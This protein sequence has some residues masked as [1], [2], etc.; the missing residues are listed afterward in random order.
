MREPSS[1]TRPLM[2]VVVVP[3]LTDN[4]SYLIVDVTSRQT[5]VVDVSE[6]DKVVSAAATHLPALALSL[7]LSTHHHACAHST[8]SFA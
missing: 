2:E 6:P 7:V 3:Q 4:Y 1:F 5:A 8:A